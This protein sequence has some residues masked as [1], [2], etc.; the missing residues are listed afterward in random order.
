M[1]LWSA[2]FIFALVIVVVGLVL[3]GPNFP[4]DPFE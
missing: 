4:D 2:L 3:G 1:D